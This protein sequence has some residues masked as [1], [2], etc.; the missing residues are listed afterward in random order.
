M[1]L[2]EGVDMGCELLV[3][4]VFVAVV[5]VDELQDGFVEEGAVTIL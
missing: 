4:K 3:E 2:H 5:S 1:E